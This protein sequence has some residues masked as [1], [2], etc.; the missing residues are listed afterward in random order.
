MRRET[1][2]GIRAQMESQSS[3]CCVSV[4]WSLG[5][6]ASV[7]PKDNVSLVELGYSGKRHILPAE[8]IKNLGSCSACSLTELRGREY[9]H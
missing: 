5:L 2:K 8:E 7:F 6:R 4:V 3:C 1:F 9:H